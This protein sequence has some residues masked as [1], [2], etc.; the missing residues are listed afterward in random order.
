MELNMNVS[1]GAY[2]AA[3][4][5]LAYILRPKAVQND[6]DADDL[7]AFFDEMVKARRRAICTVCEMR[8]VYAQGKC[9]RCYRQLR[10]KAG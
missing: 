7:R 4:D 1:I 8:R 5:T 9:E 6:P 10:R 3:Y 2:K